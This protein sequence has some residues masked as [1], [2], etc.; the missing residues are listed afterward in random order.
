MC[1]DLV[2]MNENGHG[3]LFCVL[4]QYIILLSKLV[5]NITTP[6]TYNEGFALSIALVPRRLQCYSE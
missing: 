3:Q 6:Y 5:P 1:C 4:N 2:L